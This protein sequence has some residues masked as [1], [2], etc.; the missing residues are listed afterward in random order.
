MEPGKSNLA[1][2]FGAEKPK[3]ATVAGFSTKRRERDTP[4]TPAIFIFI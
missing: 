2:L 1:H 4:H 3:P